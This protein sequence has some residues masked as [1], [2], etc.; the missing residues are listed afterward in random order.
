[1]AGKDASSAV[2]RKLNRSIFVFVPSIA[3]RLTAFCLIAGLLG[4]AVAFAQTG[5][6]AALPNAVAGPAPAPVAASPRCLSWPSSTANRSSGR[7]LAN[8]CLR[9]YGE[10]VLENLINRQIIAQA[11]QARNVVITDKDL[12]T[13]IRFVAER[14]GLTVDRWLSV[15]QSERNIDPAQYRT[16]IIWPTLALRRLAS[17]QVAVTTRSSARRSNPSTGRR[18][19]RA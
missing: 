14:F 19:R 13:E 1:M 6:P 10:E 5:P 3:R 9:R 4:T 12:D 16:D 2:A 8:E 7:V 17:T 18:S 15:L 11:C